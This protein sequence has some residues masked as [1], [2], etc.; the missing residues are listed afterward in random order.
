MSSS[1]II[2]SPNLL[3]PPVIGESG[4]GGD[5]AGTGA[6]LRLEENVTIKWPALVVA[7]ERRE[8][9]QRMPSTEITRTLYRK[10]K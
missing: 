2:I 8:F 10:I 5:E 3:P 9:T 4:V 1:L 6:I 7:K